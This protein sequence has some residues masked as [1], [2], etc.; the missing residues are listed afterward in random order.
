M[1]VNKGTGDEQ[2]T[3]CLHVD[4][5]KIT[6]RNEDTIE[7]LIDSLT[8]KYQTLTVHREN[9]HSYLGMTWDY[10]T[11]GRVKITME[12]VLDGYEVT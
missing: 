6:C 2:C 5:L 10:S 8:T 1:R 3:I 9:V 12:D 7:Q 11:L 4:D